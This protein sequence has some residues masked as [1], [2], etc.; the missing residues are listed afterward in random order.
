MK[1]KLF[2]Y[3]FFIVSL[4]IFAQE[5]HPL[6]TEDF[7]VQKAWV[8]STYQAMNLDQ[9][10][11]QLFMVD[12]FSSKSKAETDKIKELIKE[13]YIGGIIFSKGG[14]MRQAKLNN[15]Y[16]ELA[17]VPLLI[18]MDAE[19]G[20]AMRLDSTYAF[21]WNMTLG[22][23]EDNRL[24]KK[25]GAQIA[26]HC[27]RLG[28]HINFAPVADVNNNPDNP[29]IGNRSFGENKI[30]VTEKAIAFMQGMHSEGVLSSAKHFPG[31]GDTDVDSHKSLPSLD[32][33]KERLDSLE[34]YPFKRM[35]AED[36]SSIMIGHLNVPA[37]DSRVNF[38]F[39]IIKSNC[40]RFTSGKT[41]L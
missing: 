30:N 37:L 2:S 3:L 38:P 20:L 29:I 24:I 15:E 27:K 41:K 18:G 40:D 9:K 21:P 34:L 11:G 32:F 33:S 17:N 36:V 6:K 5:S 4:G 10:I 26:K 23:I 31:H 19:W 13:N 14:P 7:R 39:F 22:A 8:D 16:Q 12:I 1:V 25:T 35:I 28:V